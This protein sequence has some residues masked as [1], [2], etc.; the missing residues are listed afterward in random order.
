MGMT[1]DCEL[2][3]YMENGLIYS[4]HSLCFGDP[5]FVNEQA[6]SL[7]PLGACCSMNFH[8]AV[9]KTETKGTGIG[10]PRLLFSP[11]AA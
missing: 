1:T 10:I 5:F 2:L 7:S 3:P 8:F 11:P 4:S 6:S 9:W